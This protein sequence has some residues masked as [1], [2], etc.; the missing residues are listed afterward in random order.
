MDSHNSTEVVSIIMPCYNAQ[1]TLAK[2]L[3]SIFSQTYTSFKL[4]C[5]N[6]GSTDNTQS[7]LDEYQNKF[8]DRMWVLS[9]KNKGQTISKNIGIQQS[10]GEY[11]AF[12]DSDDLWDPKKLDI[13]LSAMRADPEVGLSYT[14][15]YYIDADDIQHEKIGID[16]ILQ[17]QCFKRILMGNAIVASSVM[18]RRS[19]I[20]KIGLFDETLTACENWELWTRIAS[21]CPLKALPDPLTYYRRHDANMSHNFEKMVTNRLRVVHNNI[22]RYKHSLPDSKRI[23]RDALFRSYQFFGENYLWKMQLNKA[24]SHLWAAICM[25][26]LKI[27][28]YLLLFKTLMGVKLISLLR[29]IRGRKYG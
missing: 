28:P 12:I 2:T 11:I 6:D 20:N 27:K 17:G 25:K 7:I 18:I 1:K 14:D 13:Q 15:G 16:P 10:Q 21:V 22:A 8:K 24:R 29:G 5:I 9:Q 26:P 19:I 3:D 23:M 4:Y